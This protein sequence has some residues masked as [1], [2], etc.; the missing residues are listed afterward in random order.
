MSLR[1]K[2]SVPIGRRGGLA[3]LAFAF[4]ITLGGQTAASESPTT[5]SPGAHFTDGDEELAAVRLNGET[6]AAGGLGVYYDFETEQYVAVFPVSRKA[7]RP[8]VG[9]AALGARIEFREIELETIAAVENAVLAR[10]FDRRAKDAT[11]GSY[12]DLASGKMVVDVVGDGSI[13]ADLVRRHPDAIDVREVADGGLD[14]RAND[15]PPHWGGAYISANGVSCTSGFGVRKPNGLTHMVTAA[16]CFA[17]GATVAGGTGLLWGG[18]SDRGPYPAWDMELITGNHGGSIYSGNAVGVW[19][20]VKGAANPV[21]NS[22]SY[23]VSG[24]TSNETCG[25]HAV[26]LNGVLCVP[27]GCTGG[28][29]VYRDGVVT[30]VGDSGA[31]WY[32][33]PASGGVTIRGIHIGRAGA[34]MFSERWPT[35]QAHWNLTIITN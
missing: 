3:V 35:I 6:A 22:T 16:H 7:A 32:N 33:Y 21:V 10:T 19:Q 11:Y 31:P 30:Q 9:L 28:L 20:P 25:H 14:S 34:D 1:P 17:A 8:D 18:V 4:A 15:A 26:A 27:A 13:F 24:R 5:I 12:L 23:C 29:A 2:S